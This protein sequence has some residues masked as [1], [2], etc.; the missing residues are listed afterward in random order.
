MVEQQQPAVTRK[1]R[2]AAELPG[3][4]GPPGGLAEA[5]G[6][7]AAAVELLLHGPAADLGRS[8]ESLV[9]VTPVAICGWPH[10]TGAEGR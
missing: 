8:H 10:L 1:L 9:F 3:V 6:L 5:C 4:Q 7:A 2:H